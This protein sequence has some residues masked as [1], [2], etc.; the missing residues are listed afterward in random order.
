MGRRSCSGP[1]SKRCTG[2]SWKYG[3]EI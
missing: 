2:T 3:Y 1:N